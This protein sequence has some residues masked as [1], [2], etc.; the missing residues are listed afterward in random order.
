MR[1]WFLVSGG[2]LVFS[3]LLFA[4]L[5]FVVKAP[6]LISLGAAFGLVTLLLWFWSRDIPARDL[7]MRESLWNT[8]EDEEVDDGCTETDAGGVDIDRLSPSVQ[9][10]SDGVGTHPQ[11]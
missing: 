4:L 11:P 6:I 2:W 10:G 1:F 8:P 9:S 7:V 5:V 3:G